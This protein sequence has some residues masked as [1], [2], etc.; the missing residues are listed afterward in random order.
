MLKT[1]ETKLVKFKL[2]GSIVAPFGYE[3]EICHDGKPRYLPSVGGITLNFLVGDAANQYIGDHLEP[4]VTT[5]M[6]PND[7]SKNHSRRNTGY[8]T[9][10][11]IG[12]EATVISGPAKGSKGMVTGHHGGV[13]HVLIDFDAGTL[14]KLTYDDKIMITAFGVGL[15]IKGFEHIKIFSIAPKLLKK[16][17]IKPV[18][19]KLHVGVAAI[20]PAVAMGSGLG[21]STSFKGDYDIQTSDPETNKKFGLDRL[22]LGDIVA[23]IDHD[24]SYGWSYKQGA[25]SIGVIIH[26]D[27]VLAG[28]GPGCQTIMTSPDGHIVPVIDKTA[29][30]GKLLK[31]GRYRSKK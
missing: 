15:E 12:N 22:C 23:I 26:G 25:I 4:G 3:W 17:N 1:N 8:N 18:K 29:N 5:S 16:I 21:G 24:S 30:I 10:S 20:I 14:N 6:E 28:H 19:N 27:C 2:Q 7:G 11:C 9:F 13:E 31:I